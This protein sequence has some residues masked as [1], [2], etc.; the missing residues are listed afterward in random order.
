MVKKVLGPPPDPDTQWVTHSASFPC[1]RHEL[2]T[3]DTDLFLLERVASSTAS[4]MK[5]PSLYLT[6]LFTKLIVMNSNGSS[7][8]SAK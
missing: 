8:D 5:P 3:D 2:I 6:T 1:F 4:N 7:F